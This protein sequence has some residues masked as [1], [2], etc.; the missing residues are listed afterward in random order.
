[1]E[2]DESKICS[3]SACGQQIC[4][5]GMDATPDISVL[6]TTM[7]RGDCL[8]GSPFGCVSPADP[9]TSLHYRLYGFPV[10][11]PVEEIPSKTS[12]FTGRQVPRCVVALL[13]MQGF[14]NR[15]T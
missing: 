2:L 5:R 14:L 4:L 15:D 10:P 12:T 7:T 13:P 9:A 1:M 6:T 8:D 11:C 3:N